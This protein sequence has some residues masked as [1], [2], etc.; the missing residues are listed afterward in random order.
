MRFQPVGDNFA[1][2]HATSAYEHLAGDF[3]LGIAF[4]LVASCELFDAFFGLHSDVTR[5]GKHDDFRALFTLGSEFPCATGECI[6]Q[7][8]AFLQGLKSQVLRGSQPFM[9]GGPWT[10][11]GIRENKSF[12][13]GS[14][15]RGEREEFNFRDNLSALAG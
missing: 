9:G 10:Q 8:F 5:I 2:A 13:V 1:L 4:P 15:S 3:D 6:G 11:I 12:S 7:L 14:A